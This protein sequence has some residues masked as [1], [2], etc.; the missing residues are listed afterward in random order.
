M[1]KEGEHKNCYLLNIIEKKLFTFGEKGI[2]YNKVKENSRRKLMK[3]RE[4]L[5]SSRVQETEAYVGFGSSFEELK[6]AV[7]DESETSPQGQSF[8]EFL[9]WMKE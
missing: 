5:D 8:E 9:D 4:F 7:E 1:V 3:L 6:E 2:L